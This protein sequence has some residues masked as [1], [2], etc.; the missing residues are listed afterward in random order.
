MRRAIFEQSDFVNKTEH[1]QLLTV[2]Q[3]L[4]KVLESTKIK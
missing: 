4:N 2:Y 3:Q 1:F